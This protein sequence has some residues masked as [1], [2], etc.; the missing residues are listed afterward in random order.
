M[1]HQSP[2]DSGWLATIEQ[3][4][5]K[6]VDIH[7]VTHTKLIV[8]YSKKLS[9]LLYYL[10]SL[11]FL[12]VFPNKRILDIMFRSLQVGYLFKVY[13]NTFSNRV[14]AGSCLISLKSF[15][16][17][18][19]FHFLRVWKCPLLVVIW[20]ICSLPSLSRAIKRQRHSPFYQILRKKLLPLIFNGVKKEF[21]MEHIFGIS[22]HCI[23][24]DSLSYIYLSIYHITVSLC[25]SSKSNPSL[26][27]VVVVS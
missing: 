19:P 6:N 24:Q 9:D 26:H 16:T 27:F 23:R 7:K 2:R 10:K 5:K 20:R 15:I 21:D 12:P 13:R 17:P 4:E 25:L 11:N 14:N 22:V 18:F 1:C 8:N 3:I